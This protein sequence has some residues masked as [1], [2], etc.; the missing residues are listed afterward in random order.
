MNK[1]IIE[2][3]TIAIVTIT[4]LAI[5]ILGFDKALDNWEIVEC[6][7]LQSYAEK[8]KNYGGFYITAIEKEMCDYHN[9]IVDAPV[10]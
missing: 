10:R 1:K 8:Y 4:M 6:Y 9:I 7:K 2:T 5:V 3:I